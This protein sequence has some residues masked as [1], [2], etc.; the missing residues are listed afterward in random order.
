MYMFI[1]KLRAFLSKLNPCHKSKARRNAEYFAMRENETLKPTLCE[2]VHS[3]IIKEYKWV[4]G[5]F[6]TIIGMYIAYLKL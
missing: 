3:F 4:V 2:K 1:L 5:I 6:L